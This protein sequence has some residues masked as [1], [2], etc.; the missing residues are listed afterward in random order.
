[1]GRLLAA[2]IGLSVLAG[3]QPGSAQDS[4]VLV[5]RLPAGAIQPQVVADSSFAHVVY[6]R[7]EAAAGD[8]FYARLDDTGA[9]SAPVR[10]NSQPASAVA[11]GN[12][13]GARLALGRNGQ[14]HVTWNGSGRAAPRGPANTTPMLYTRL[15]TARTAFAAQRNLLQ[16]AVGLDGGG[17]IAADARGR[18]VVAWHAGGPQSKDETTR[19][20]WVA[21]ST[22]DGA[23]F[24]REVPASP[25]ET[26]ACGCCG[27]AG[28]I[29]RNGRVALLYR[30]ARNLVHRDT[31][32]LMSA[33]TPERFS[34]TRLQEWNVGACPMSSFSL[35]EGGAGL[36]AAW[37]TGGQVQFARIDPAA[38]P[39]S[40]AV[41]APG[42]STTRKHPIVVGNSQGELL[43]V[44]TEGMSWQRGGSVAW[45]RFDS[46]HQPVGGVER[47]PGVPTWS[48]VAA[49]ARPDGR[50]VVVY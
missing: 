20:V 11:A 48:L 42:P 32:L 37:E 17:A 10:V 23:T 31:Y 8:L 43:F 46:S 29:T 26:G 12:I 1:M 44:W 24:A 7:G 14:V 33:D 22:D 28:L 38:G 5:V 13:R 27:M 2:L 45:Q 25:V 3:L 49:Y 15:N 35:S 50:F 36:L 40:P 39:P 16:H 4:G 18:V 30:A 6:F 9:W 34:A 21:E 41:Q 47:R 19:R